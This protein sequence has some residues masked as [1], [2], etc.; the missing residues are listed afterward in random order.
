MGGGG[1]QPRLGREGGGESPRG[2]AV[3]EDQQRPAGGLCWAGRRC[4][5]PAGGGR[6][7]PG[8]YFGP[9]KEWV[10]DTG[11]EPVTSSV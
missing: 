3:G 5:T 9:G 8:K 4:C 6:R 7:Q 11:F 2:A 10:G 1:N